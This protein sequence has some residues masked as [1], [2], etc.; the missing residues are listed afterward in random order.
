M[1]GTHHQVPLA[2]RPIRKS[3]V[4]VV[5]GS[6]FDGQTR[7][8]SITNTRRRRLPA[9]MD[10]IG[11]APSTVSDARGKIYMVGCRFRGLN[12]GVRAPRRRTS[13]SAKPLATPPFDDAQGAPSNV[14]GRKTLG[15][16]LRPN[17]ARVAP[18]RAGTQPRGSPQ[19]PHVF[20]T[21]LSAWLEGFAARDAR[22]LRRFTPAG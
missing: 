17:D 3:R 21:S 6:A 7:T 2:S 14:E 20:I 5:F 1:V 8:H 18:A 15:R 4:S 9:C 22:S 19:P 16:H 12:C 13:R 11:L 10:L